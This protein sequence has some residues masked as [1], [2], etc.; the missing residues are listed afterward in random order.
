MKKFIFIFILLFVSINFISAAEITVRE[1]VLK[2]ETMI[3]KISG[4]F[5]QPLTESNIHFY[6]RHMP[7]SMGFYDLIKIQEEY[8]L[9]VNIPLEKIADNYSIVV[10]DAT[11]KVGTQTITSDF[12]GNFTIPEEEV[13]FTLTPGI[14]ISDTNYTIDILNLE[15]NTIVVEYKQIEYGTQPEPSGNGFIAD[16]LGLFEGESGGEEI[17]TGYVNLL[18]G[19]T[20]TIEILPQNYLGFQEIE[21]NYE[22]DSYAVLAWIEEEIIDP[23]NDT[24]PGNVTIVDNETIEEETFE[25]EN[26][27]VEPEEEKTFFEKLFGKDDENETEEIIIPEGGALETCDEMG[28]QVCSEGFACSIDIVYAES[29]LCCLGECEVV[30][31][32]STGKTIGWIIIIIVVLFLTWFFKKKYKAKPKPV[33]LLKV[34]KK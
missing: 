24:E 12:F 30:E 10:K 34:G 25:E 7:T 20:K 15:P 22:N 27:T 23:E 32:N 29:S 18:S 4:N 3:A 8:Y 5:I 16:I 6:R 17:E 2:G 9:Y 21:F 19:Q 14:L 13:P 11:Y 26:I 31:K 1:E 28:G 33:N